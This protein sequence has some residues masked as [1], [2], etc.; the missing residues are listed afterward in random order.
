MTVLIYGDDYVIF[1]SNYLMGSFILV[2]FLMLDLPCN[3][4]K[5]STCLFVHIAAFNLLIFN[6]ETL[7]SY[8]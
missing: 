1:L 5:D 7:R 8:L 2:D 4:G 3:P 6:S